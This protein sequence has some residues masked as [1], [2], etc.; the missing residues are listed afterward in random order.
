VADIVYKILPAADWAADGAVVPWSDDDRRDGFV[1]LSAAGQVF[2]TARRRFSGR[3]GLIVLAIDAAL[4]GPDLRCERSRGG[5]SFPHYYG[6]IARSAVVGARTL[7]E[8]RPG[9]FA[10]GDPL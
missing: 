7:V 6:E 5:A 1:H 8:T 9:E 10:F 2:E 3:A 4:A